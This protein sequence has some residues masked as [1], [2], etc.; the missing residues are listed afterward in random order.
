MCLVLSCALLCA[1]IA[2][3]EWKSCEF[4]LE[5]LSGRLA[6]RYP[7]DVAFF[8]FFT[9]LSTIASMVSVY[10]RPLSVLETPGS[11]AISHVHV[12]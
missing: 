6:N 4:I 3:R 7:K 5:H 8:A 1:T 10:C 12:T 9:S 2:H 11:G